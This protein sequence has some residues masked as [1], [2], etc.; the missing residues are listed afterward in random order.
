VEFYVPELED[1]V[2]AAYNFEY[3]ENARLDK[4]ERNLQYIWDIFDA[5]T[6][7]IDGVLLSRE[8]VG[9][10]QAKLDRFLTNGVYDKD[11]PL[12]V[13][14]WLPTISDCGAWG[15]KSLPFPPYDNEGMLEFY[16]TLG[17]Q[18]GVTIDHLVLGSGQAGRL[19]LDKRAF[20]ESYSQDDLPKDL[21]NTVD[22]MVDEWPAEWPSYV[23]KHEPSICEYQTVKPFDADLFDGPRTRYWT[24]WRMIH[25]QSTAKM[26]RSSGTGSPWKMRPK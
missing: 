1:H 20:N 23:T 21:V 6:L 5:E 11:S 14:G 26:I 25:G 8:Q 22:L 19:Y 15:Y 12:A 13:P 9:D 18:V 3:D 17:I 10:S 7:P 16:E 4:S 24:G 2:D